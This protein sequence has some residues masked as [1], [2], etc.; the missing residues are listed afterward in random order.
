M[1]CGDVNRLHHLYIDREL[2]P[3]DTM[4]VEE[5]LQSCDD[6][7]EACDRDRALSKAIRRDV[8]RYQAPMEL[9]D[10]IS[11]KLG[12]RERQSFRSLR[13]LAVG[14]NP[15]AIAASLVL[16]IITSSA[17][18]TAHLGASAAEDQVVQEVVSSHVRSLMA[19]HLTD[20]ASSDQH[21]V[22]PW[23]TGKV[24]ASPPAV[25]LA[26][27]GFP[28]IGGRLDYV[29]QR[30]CAV[31]VYRHDKH[32]INVLVWADR[33]S[34]PVSTETYARQ[35]YN[36]IRFNQDDMNFWAVSDLNRTELD[37]FVGR[38]AIAA[39]SADVRS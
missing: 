9:R 23:F 19:N 37:E 31:L 25:D 33:G 18:T 27:A 38:L 32:I 17:L 26:S 7:R 8:R 1:N 35:G 3:V 2:E 28:L 30:P 22:K 21:T 13:Y 5:H 15:I 39:R 11:R 10:G 36:L 34:E 24:D 29:D 16:T 6:C 4:R 14:W 20:V 12:A